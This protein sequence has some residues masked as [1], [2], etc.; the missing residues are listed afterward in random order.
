MADSELRKE[1]RETAEAK[2]AALHS[3]M[4]AAL[5]A[6]SKTNEGQLVLRYILREAHFLAPLT[7][8]TLSG[9]N[10][11]LLLINEAKRQIYLALRAHMDR[12][13]ILRVELPDKPTPI[14]EDTNA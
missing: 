12:E 7:N 4:R 14:K 10:R 5:S 8:E 9:V 6:L 11:D 3:N 1:Q 13:T 2:I